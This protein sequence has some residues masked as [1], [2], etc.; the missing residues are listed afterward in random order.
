MNTEG[1]TLENPMK[2]QENENPRESARTE[3]DADTYELVE[4]EAE[5]K[6]SAQMKAFKKNKKIVER[7]I[8]GAYPQLILAA[9]LM[10]SL[11]M[12]DSWILGNA[13]DSSNEILNGTLMVVFVIF[14]FETIIL[15]IVQEGYYLSFFFWMD[16]IGTLSI[17]LD[18]SW[19][20]D[21]FIPSGVA[22]SQGSVLRATKA[23]KLGARYG[24]LM[25]MLK[26]LKFMKDIPCLKFLQD[27]DD[28]EPTMGTIR[29][30][31]EELSQL[32]SLRVAALV[33]ILVIVMPF[34][35][36]T[37]V[38]YSENAWL[39]NLRILAKNESV[40]YYDVDY[41]AQRCDKFYNKKD[42]DLVALRIESPWLETFYENQY[43][44]RHPLRTDNLIIYESDYHFTAGQLRE[45]GVPSA[46]ASIPPNTS[47]MT[48]VFFKV[49]MEVDT[50]VEN[51]YDAMFSIIVIVLVIIILFVFTGSFNSAV[52]S[53]VVQPLEKMLTTLR[54]SAMLMLKSLEAVEKVKKETES[55]VGDSDSDNEDEEMETAMLE[56]MVEKLAKIVKH[57]LPGSTEITVD[58]GIDKTTAN[59]LNEAY[60]TGASK[61]REAKQD[62][63][64]IDESDLTSDF[65]EEV[66][67]IKTHLED[68]STVSRDMINCW[69]FDVLGYS[70]SDLGIIV[71]YMFS[72]MNLLKEFKVPLTV[73]QSFVGEIA[74]RY[75]DTNTYHNFKHGVDV[76]HTTYRLLMLTSLDKVLSSLEVFSLLVGALAHDVGHP[77]INNMYMVK[78]KHELALAHN[79]RSP[80][81]NMHCVVLYEVLRSTQSNVFVNLKDAQWR[82][83]RKVILTVILATDMQH[84]FE[85]ISKTQLFSEINKDDTKSFYDGESEEMECM[86]DDKNRMFV[87][88]LVLHCSDIS[89][90]YKPFNICAKWADLVVEE[91]WRQGDKEAEEGLEI[92]NMCN[93]ADNV[94]KGYL[95]N[96][97]MG[98]IEFVV[99]P[100]INAFITI[101]PPLYE[102][103]DNMTANMGGWS[104]RLRVEIRAD[105]EVS[106]E[107]KEEGIK[108]ADERLAKFVEKMK[109]VEDLK[110]KANPKPRASMVP[111]ARKRDI[112]RKS[113][114]PGR[115]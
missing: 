99:A 86:R 47:N 17:L 66:S 69:T 110:A 84:H 65:D 42:T 114:V 101:F 11:F 57:V 60:S 41:H 103:G 68:S 28:Y 13:P 64:G 6:H 112:S 52:K 46:I 97:Q 20:T 37:V 89:N 73:F 25:R 9:L 67:E 70:N 91:F 93:R 74:S 21:I 24:R 82:D 95:A 33:M 36:Y 62:L 8:N 19:I 58:A 53:L 43:D 31:S 2:I 108:K 76:C 16:I 105:G 113:M 72:Q 94:K 90:P 77:G 80:L 23:A 32:L 115:G 59:W 40:T 102:L 44:R 106:A 88:E 111:D 83:A 10:L 34:L 12:A 18:I 100:L 61:Q 87:M 5:I 63:P 71:T 35:N 15:T 98:F 49:N 38:D 48:D 78:S 96:M 1:I 104:E 29:K 39:V 3:H 85:Q 55:D 92:S 79:D 26:F 75:I 81:E 4:N 109:F 22:A 45:S 56:K 7:W 27:D 51:Q 50:T 14:V 30:V 107:D 54:N